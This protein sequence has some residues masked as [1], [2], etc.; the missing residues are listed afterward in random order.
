MPDTQSQHTRELRQIK[1]LLVGIFACTAVVAVALLPMMVESLVKIAGVVI[2]V[3]GLAGLC[4]AAWLLV[5][6]LFDRVQRRQH[7]AHR[8]PAE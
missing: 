3:L 8:A 5:S 4:Y 6:Y 1:W 7:A 2:L